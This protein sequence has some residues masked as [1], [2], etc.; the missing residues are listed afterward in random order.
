M[1]AKE[2]LY[3]LIEKLPESEHHTARRFLEYLCNAEQDPLWRALRE[4]PIDDELETPEERAAVEEALREFERGETIP[5]E[6]I[7]R[8]LGLTHGQKRRVGKVRAG[9]SQATRS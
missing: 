6:R 7:R 5:H 9:R 1:T 3:Q 4:A 2:E 8:E